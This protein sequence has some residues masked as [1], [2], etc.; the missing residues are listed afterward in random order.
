MVIYVVGKP[1]N[2][3]ELAAIFMHDE[4]IF[5]DDTEEYRE[6]KLYGKTPS[7]CIIDDCQVDAKTLIKNLPEPTISE[8]TDDSR[9]RSKGERRR[10]RRHR[11]SEQ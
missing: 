2:R 10:N 6:H 3:A 8:C 5:V 7:I 4:I 11:W 1:K 9:R